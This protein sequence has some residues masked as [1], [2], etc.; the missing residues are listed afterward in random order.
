M[1]HSAQ[2]S[3]KSG[4]LG[5]LVHGAVLQGRRYEASLDVWADGLRMALEDPYSEKCTLKIRRGYNAY[6]LV[7]PYM[8]VHATPCAHLVY[9]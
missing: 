6:T 5:S 4:G 2:W 1:L 9:T 8:Y 3:F 7:Y